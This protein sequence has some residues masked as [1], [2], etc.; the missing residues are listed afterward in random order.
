MLTLDSTVPVHPGIDM[1]LLGLGVYLLEKDSGDAAILAALDHG[2]RHIDTA[3]GYGN[4]Q[5]VGRALRDAGVP[6][7][8]VFLTSKMGIDNKS[9]QDAADAIDDSLRRL[10]TDYLDLYLIHWPH[11]DTMADC[12][13]AMAD[14]QQ[15][16]KLRAIGL[17]NY[18]ARRLETFDRLCG[19]G[20]AVN[21]LEYHCF[22]Q[23]RDARAACE[24]RG[25]RLTGYCPLARGQRLDHP[26]LIAIADKHGKTPAQVMIRWSLQTGVPTIPKSSRPDRVASNADVFDFELDATDLATLDHHDGDH[27]ANTWRPAGAWY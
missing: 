13:A 12:W 17:S 10:D 5:T 26:Q 14:A 24:Q 7:D 23:Q 6:R 18:T 3:T 15:A 8:Q 21:Q 1:P 20:A 9:R 22:H 19:G 11:D 25:I 4:E 2:Y 27:E 16:G